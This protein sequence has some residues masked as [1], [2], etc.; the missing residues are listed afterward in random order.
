MEALLFATLTTTQVQHG[1]VCE[2]VH[3]FAL[4][5]CVCALTVIHGHMKMK[6]K[7]SPYQRPVYAIFHF[8]LFLLLLLQ[9]IKRNSNNDGFLSI[10]VL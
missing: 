7:L 9:L 3:T 2:C 8:S 4:F 6:M 1:E 10:I 5:A